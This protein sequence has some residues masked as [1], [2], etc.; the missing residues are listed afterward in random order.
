M[1]EN[2]HHTAQSIP[3]FILICNRSAQERKESMRDQKHITIW[4]HGTRGKEIAPVFLSPTLRDIE[5]RICFCPPGLHLTYDIDPHW[6]VKKI[7]QLISQGNSNEFPLESFYLFGWSGTLD[8]ASRKEE[9]KQLYNALQHLYAQYT[10]NDIAPKITII[11]HSHGGNVA[12]NMVS[13]YNQSQ[14]KIIID[15]LLLLACPIQEETKHFTKSELFTNIYS[16]HSHADLLQR[17]DPQNTHPLIHALRE[18]L[19]ETS[20]APF[21]GLW[22][23]LFSKKQSPFFSQRH[24]EHAPKIKQA[25]IAWKTIKPWSKEDIALFSPYIE[26]IALIARLFKDQR[27][28]GHLEFMMP[29]FLRNLPHII[30]QLDHAK[31]KTDDIHINL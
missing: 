14:Q 1:Q 21:K 31:T 16:L 30:K 13:A 2:Q 18:S 19:R 17:L 26:Q 11:T 12:L 8:A 27:S 28:L 22:K 3:I 7:A 25:T 15:R 4:I 5:K 20:L 6:Y 23:R 9:A 29:T 10:H 24:F